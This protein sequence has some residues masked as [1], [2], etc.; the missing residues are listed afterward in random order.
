MSSFTLD[1]QT[2]LRTYVL[3][4]AGLAFQSRLAAPEGVMHLHVAPDGRVLD[5]FVQHVVPKLFLL[6]ELD[7]LAGE[8]SWP[9]PVDEVR[10]TPARKMTL[11]LAVRQELIATLGMVDAREPAWDA[12]FAAHPALLQD[13]SYTLEDLRAFRQLE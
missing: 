12:F 10:A 6:Q 1:L 8:A 4:L 5:V 3:D 2:G 9:V 13:T 7:R 11:E